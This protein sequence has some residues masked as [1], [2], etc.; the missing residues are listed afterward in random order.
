MCTTYCSLAIYLDSIY[1]YTSSLHNHFHHIYCGRDQNMGILMEYISFFCKKFHLHISCYTQTSSPNLPSVV[2]LIKKIAV[3]FFPS[4]TVTITYLD[5]IVHY[6]SF[7]HSHFR[8]TFCSK[9]LDTWIG[10]TFS[11]CKKFLLHTSCY[12]QTS[13]PIHP[14]M[15]FL[16]I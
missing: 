9:D 6:T 16:I 1:H 10:S 15:V 4:L 3:K 12:T 5:N 8:H 11:F 7:P 2:F 14:S 13:S